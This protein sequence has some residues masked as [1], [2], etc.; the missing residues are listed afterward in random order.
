ML[1]PGKCQYPFP[2]G[3]SWFRPANSWN[4]SREDTCWRDFMRCDISIS[5]ERELFLGTKTVRVLHSLYG[6]CL[7]V[8]VGRFS[9]RIMAAYL[10]F[11]RWGC[12]VQDLVFPWRALFRLRERP[13]SLS[14]FTA[15][16][17]DC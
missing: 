4:G 10:L 12:V 2:T 14:L 5:G 8:C 11:S 16:R 17:H 9:P 3:A 1:L 6:L 15:V 13:R 7:L